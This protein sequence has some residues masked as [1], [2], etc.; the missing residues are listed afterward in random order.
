[1]S[2]S[3][4]V[5]LIPYQI[6]INIG[7]SPVLIDISL[8]FFGEISGMF[9]LVPNTSYFLLDYFQI[10]L[11]FFIHLSLSLLSIPIGHFWGSTSETSGLVNVITQNMFH[12]FPSGMFQSD[13]DLL[14]TMLPIGGLFWST[15]PSANIATFPKPCLF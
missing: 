12:K 15:S 9:S 6:N 11:Y 10:I 13:F 3:L 4:L 14:H 8:V 1:M 2:V 5:G 7:I